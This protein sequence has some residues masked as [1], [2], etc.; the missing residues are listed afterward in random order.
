MT[1]P[2][3]PRLRRKAA[4]ALPGL[5]NWRGMSLVSLSLVLCACASAPVGTGSTAA[6]TAAAPPVPVVAP[7]NTSAAPARTLAA[8]TDLAAAPRTDAGVGADIRTHNALFK[9]SR[10]AELP[11]WGQD[12]LDTAWDA[13]Q[14][15]CQALSRRE[16]WKPLC[17]RAAG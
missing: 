6:Q 11:G 4:V 1:F 14:S 9:A 16:A 8:P 7:A 12:D 5:P 3:P 15:S 13:F 2:A 10:F 17:A